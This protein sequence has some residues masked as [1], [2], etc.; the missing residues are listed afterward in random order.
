MANTYTQIHLQ[1]IFAVQ[2][3]R[4]LI[5]QTWKERLYKYIT[6]I[7]QNQGHKI[8]IINGMPDHLHIVTGMRPIQAVSELLQFIKRDSSKWINENKLVAGKF[9]WQDGF[10]AFS[11]SRSQLPALI[12]YVLNQEIHHSK[13][14]FLTEYTEMLD[15]FEITY[16]KQYLFH[17][18]E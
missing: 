6:S 3:R 10:G 14:T 17:E 7:V 9:Q 18:I 5:Q 1:F 11:Y 8:I 15:K 2:N 13:K 16:E 12:N 4:S